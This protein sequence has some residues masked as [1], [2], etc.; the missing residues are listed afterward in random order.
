MRPL[1]RLIAAA[2]T[3]APGA[4][5]AGPTLSLNGINID[6]VTSQRFENCTVTIDAQGNVNIEAKGYAVRRAGAVNGKV[7]TPPA[8]PIESAPPAAAP[9]G[10]AAVAAV[11]PAR[12][13]RRYFLAT[14]QT[15]PDGTQFDIE[16]FV[17]AQWIRQLRSN[18]AQVVL[19]ITKYLRAGPN[20]VVLAAR[21]AIA[22]ERV[23]SSPDVTFQ[24]VI[25][26]GNMGGDHVMIDNPLVRM[27]RTAAE[28]E[29]VTEEFTLVAR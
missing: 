22:G 9:P 10:G 6:G 12:L 29:N 3:A 14:E 27:R 4:S 24:V 20:K 11:D 21:K 28:T 16:V 13:T 25:G 8:A 2:L 19:E 7:P 1:A 23:S 18:E 26:E 17:N 15:R 5:L